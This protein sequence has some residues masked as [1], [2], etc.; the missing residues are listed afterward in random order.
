VSDAR[1]TTATRSAESPAALPGVKV[2][3]CTY[4]GAARLPATLQHLAAQRVPAHLE[5]EVLLVDNAS[6]HRSAAVAWQCWA[7]DAPAALRVV[8][9][10]ELQE[11]EQSL[12][13]TPW[14]AHRPD[15]VVRH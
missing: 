1:P 13:H 12:Q 3:I 9:R 8:S 2:A 4:N 5:W 10:G 15:D 6:N 14:R 7:D 11:I